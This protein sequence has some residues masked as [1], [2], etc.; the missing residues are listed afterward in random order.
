LVAGGWTWRAIA[1]V[2]WRS[3]LSRGES[4]G[5]GAS[6]GPVGTWTKRANAAVLSIALVPAVELGIGDSGDWADA[7]GTTT[8]VMAIDT[9]TMRN[10]GT[11]TGLM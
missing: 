7:I 11:D 9:A 3:S 2:A 1:I 10:E 6:T 8:S 5:A 4:F